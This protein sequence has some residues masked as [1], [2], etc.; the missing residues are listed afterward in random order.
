MKPCA[1]CGHCCEA[2]LC[3]PASLV[4]DSLPCPALQRDDNGTAICALVAAEA[5]SG[6][7]PLLR[8]G[9]GIGLGC[10]S[11][12]RRGLAEKGGGHE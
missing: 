3:Y 5:V 10:M 2:E 11:A 1:R 6:R 4:F 7:A 8:D 9:L 12:A